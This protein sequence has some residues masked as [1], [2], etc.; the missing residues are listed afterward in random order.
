MPDFKLLEASHLARSIVK[1]AGDQ[2][3]QEWKMHKKLLGKD[4]RDLATQYDLLIE[5]KITR[6]LQKLFPDH[7]IYGEEITHTVHDSEYAW[8]IDPIDGTKYFATDIP[9]FTTSL[10]LTYKGQPIL[11]VVYNPVSNQ[12]YSGYQGGK[13]HMNYEDV[14]VNLNRPFSEAI[15]YA[16]LS[17]FEKLLPANQDWIKDKYFEVARHTYRVRSFGCGSL[18]LSWIATGA[19]DAFIDFT[20]QTKFFDVCA[21]IAVLEAAGGVHEYV[22]TEVGKLLVAASSDRILVSV[23]Q[24]LTQKN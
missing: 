7:S 2:L 15:V 21:G 6:N 1:E 14:S 4:A 8:Y 9:L 20:G 3:R 13:A 12:M 19:F 11:G 23:K 17:K 18:G 22:E 16:D 5:R 24:V 10:G